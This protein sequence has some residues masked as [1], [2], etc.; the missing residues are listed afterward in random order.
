[1]GNQTLGQVKVS[2]KLGAVPT[3]ALVSVGV[4][5]LQDGA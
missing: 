1:M 5:V 2:T 3:G 4:R